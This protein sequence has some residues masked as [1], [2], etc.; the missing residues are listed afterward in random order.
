VLSTQK[1]KLRIQIW[2]ELYSLHFIQLFIS[3][4]FNHMDRMKVT[5][6]PA[7]SV[8]VRVTTSFETTFRPVYVTTRRHI[9]ETPRDPYTLQSGLWYKCLSFKN[10]SLLGWDVM[11]NVGYRSFGVTRWLKSSGRSKSFFWRKLLRCNT[12][13]RVWETFC[14][15]RMKKFGHPCATYSLSA[16]SCIS[17]S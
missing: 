1:K 4:G 13:N 10:N 16:H 14:R 9:P 15:L 2:Y 3:P 11:S 12:R 7:P 5:L 17:V 8:C 6:L